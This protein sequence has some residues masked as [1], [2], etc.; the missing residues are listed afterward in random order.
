MTR[1]EF[2]T[3]AEDVRRRWPELGGWLRSQP[4]NTLDT[5]LEALE[6]IAIRDALA[7]NLALFTGDEIRPYDRDRF[8]PAVLKRSQE[9]YYRRQD[10]M[11]RAQERADDKQQQGS[12]WTLIKETPWMLR[13]YN[14]CLD[15]PDKSK[16]DKIIYDISEG[17][18]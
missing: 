4:R 18:A 8:V 5:W 6:P 7:A 11:R 10:R 15:E 17:L 2:N 12:P 16:W 13:A 14:A 3:W 9:I 1:E